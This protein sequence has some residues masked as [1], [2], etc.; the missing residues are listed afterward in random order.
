[1]SHVTYTQ[2]NGIGQITINRPQAL[3][4][5]NRSVLADMV[6]ELKRAS[7][8]DIR[9]LIITGEGGKAFIAGSD[10][11][12]ISIFDSDEAKAYSDFGNR[13][14]R[15]IEKFPVP[16][17]AAVQGYALGSG[18]EVALA[19]DMII[20]CEDA[21]FAFPELSLGITPGF[22]GMQRLAKVVGF[23]WAKNIIFTARHVNA[24]EALQ[25]GLVTAVYPKEVFVA[26]TIE[27]AALI[28]N[29]APLAIKAAKAALYN[30]FAKNQREA[31]QIESESFVSCFGS[32]DQ[33]MAMR[34]FLEKKEPD[35]FN[36]S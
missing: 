5:L 16:V 19:C 24:Q 11:G 20:A 7:L 29:N 30:G 28:A 2:S 32:K 12:E 17:I 26:K 31:A 10:I 36:G 8:T 33:R 25:I 9:C 1:M 22:G 13:V 21:N 6:K 3:N 35:P 18:F 15:L 27:T 14:M 34:A 23:S 4:A